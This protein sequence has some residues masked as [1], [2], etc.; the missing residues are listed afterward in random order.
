M[1][2]SR[3]NRQLKKHVLKE[4]IIPRRVRTILILAQLIN[5]VQ[6]LRDHLCLD[7]LLRLVN[8]LRLLDDD[9][10]RVVL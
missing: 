9:Q 8:Q 4:L 7:V 3:V 1:G 5:S 6:R 10:D 2:E